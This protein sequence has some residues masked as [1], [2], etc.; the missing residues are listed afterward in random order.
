MK[1]KKMNLKHSN[2]NELYSLASK[3]QTSET[4]DEPIYDS[5]STTGDVGTGSNVLQIAIGSNSDSK[6]DELNLG[7]GPIY[8]TAW[9]KYFKYSDDDEAGKSPKQ[10]FKNN[11]FYEQKKLFPDADLSK[12]SDDGMN[13]LE[14][15]IKSPTLFYA[16]LFRKNL[17]FISSRQI[18]LQKTIDVLH[19]D[20]ILQVQEG[21]DS[22][23]SGIQD[24]G[25]F[26]EGFCFKVLN[27][28]PNQTWVLCSETSKIKEKFMEILKNL[29]LQSQR[30]KG[31]IALP[32]TNKPNKET[33]S[34]VINPDMGP[35]ANM[36]NYT[37]GNL[38]VIF[39][40]NKQKITDGYWIILQDWTQ[41]S[42]KCGGGTS[43]LQRMCVPPK[44]GGAPCSGKA[45]LTKPCN[46][47][48]CPNI[49]DTEE[50]KK[51]NNTFTMKPV[52][53]VMPFSSRPQRYSKCVVKESD[54]M[55]TQ[56]ND[57]ISS[58]NNPLLKAINKDMPKMQIPVRAVMNNR[59]FT[60]FGGEDYHSQILTFSL[61][62]TTF[63]RSTS[64][65]DCFL[66]VDITKTGELCPFGFDP[67][68]GKMI[69]EWDYDFNLFKHQ[70]FQTRDK[71]DVKVEEELK[72]KLQDKIKNAKREILE[73]RENEIK[74][75]VEKD[76]KKKI[77]STIK[78]T[79]DI[80][81]QAIQK[82][83]NLEEMIRKEEEER[84]KREEAVLIQ[85]I[86]EEKNR[87]DCM[88]K[89]IKER[90]LENQYNLRA[91]EAEEEIS[92]IKTA[93]SE[94]VEIRRSQL[95]DQIAKMRKKAERRKASLAQQLQ[96]VRIT[97]KDTMGKVYKKG[98]VGKCKKAMEGPNER[99][100]YC[101]GNFVDD[102]NNLT[103]CKEGDDFC[104]LCCDNEF[105]DYY[106]NER[107]KCYKTTCTGKNPGEDDDDQPTN[108][109]PATGRWIWQNPGDNTPPA[110]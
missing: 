106:I 98:D 82:E 74:K 48:P 93:A 28:N 31:V 108:N 33:I 38:G 83:L 50:N 27:T 92:S 61:Q 26:S 21:G 90:Q 60:I 65:K 75:G 22:K 42:L 80:A 44:E 20:T 43:T 55:Y 2:R 54:L 69:E 88:M 37:G 102:F 76:E 66:L 64:H 59:T 95:K 81:L 109:G 58:D 62:E 35:N 16:V 79:N 12:T 17:N 1:H 40:A 63:K 30:D 10:F 4:K 3:G 91:K 15:Y 47:K 29:K 5:L 6:L 36:K 78:D 9:V 110:S 103:N 45:I 85:K 32:N 71:I 46:T 104:M 100:L 8:Y 49:N 70:C 24:F 18:Q 14:E 101:Q 34:S 77:E 11:H 94:Q 23:T 41:C 39:N 89:A 84:E 13:T 73:E 86:D 51:K 56:H 67:R 99:I 53:K 19:I 68:G 97:M 7:G 107:Q 105:G 52:V 96:T 87:S 57:K 25:N 72:K